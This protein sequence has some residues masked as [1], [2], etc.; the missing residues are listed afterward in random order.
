MVEVLGTSCPPTYLLTV[1]STSSMPVCNTTGVWFQPLTLV[2]IGSAR[3]PISSGKNAAQWTAPF[4]LTLSDLD[5]TQHDSTDGTLPHDCFQCPFQHFH[6]TA[7]RMAMITQG[8]LNAQFLTAL[9]CRMCA[10]PP[11]ALPRRFR[12][13]WPASML[14]AWCAHQTTIQKNVWQ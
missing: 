12:L 9:E 5:Q 11:A 6:I 14:S 2:L 3:V 13:P 4:R 10:A 8:A 7:W 1:L